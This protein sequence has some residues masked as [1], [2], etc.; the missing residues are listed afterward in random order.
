MT[1]LHLRS[2]RADISQWTAILTGAELEEKKAGYRARH[3][4]S[5]H[6]A[7]CRRHRRHGDR[8]ITHG[9]YNLGPGSLVTGAIGGVAGILQVLIPALGGFD[10]GPVLGQIIRAAVGGAVLTVVTGAVNRWRPE[11]R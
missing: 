4:L 10:I 1:V 3:R 5:H 7:H 9:D 2:P 8:R 11:H 6:L